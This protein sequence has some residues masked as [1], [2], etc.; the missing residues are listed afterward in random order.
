MPRNHTAAIAATATEETV[1]AAEAEET[2]DVMTDAAVII[3][4][5]AVA[6]AKV[7]AELLK[8]QRKFTRLNIESADICR[9]LFLLLGK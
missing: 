2:K 6:A 3:I 7:A 9:H 5:V 1:V 4:A 8:I